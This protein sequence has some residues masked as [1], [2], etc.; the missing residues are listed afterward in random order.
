MTSLSNTTSLITTKSLQK[1]L[2]SD[3]IF[4]AKRK[5][6]LSKENIPKVND[7][8]ILLKIIVPLFVFIVFAI[9]FLVWFKSKHNH[10]KKQYQLSVLTKPT[11]NSTSRTYICDKLIS[12]RNETRL[13]LIV[14][15][16]FE[17]EM[18]TNSNL[19]EEPTSVFQDLHEQANDTS[20]KNED[21]N[22]V[23]EMI[24]S[25]TKKD[26][27]HTSEDSFPNIIKR[28]NTLSFFTPFDSMHIR[29]IHHPPFTPDPDSTAFPTP[30]LSRSDRIQNF[31]KSLSFNTTTPKS[32]TS[33]IKPRCGLLERRGS[34]VHLTISLNQQDNPSTSLDGESVSQP[35]SS[36]YVSLIPHL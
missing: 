10:K 34:S 13:S 23:E 11:V 33:M 35:P 18:E 30:L 32:I 25:P 9:I 8:G 36:P 29:K 7:N 16:D 26:S 14:E 17:S 3:F 22:P 24:K 12:Y 15:E 4:N 31:G 28:P 2:F 27:D 20:D 6:I 21:Q 1:K 19:A 5:Y